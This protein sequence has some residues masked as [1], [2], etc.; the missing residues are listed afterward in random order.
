VPAVPGKVGGY[1]PAGLAQRAD[2]QERYIASRGIALG[3]V[4]YL[5]YDYSTRAILY[6]GR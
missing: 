3:R 4:D 6:G 5:K 2:L 1:L